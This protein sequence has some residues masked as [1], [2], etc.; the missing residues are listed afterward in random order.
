MR[1]L[2]FFLCLISAFGGCALPNEDLRGISNF[3]PQ[4][5]QLAIQLVREGSDY[6]LK[7]RYFNAEMKFRE[8]DYLF[9]KRKNI[10]VNLVNTLIRTRQF[11]LAKESIDQLSL[12]L[13]N[14]LDVKILFAKYYQ[15]KGDYQSAIKSFKQ[16]LTQARELEVVDY[17]ATIAENLSAIYFLIGEEFLALKYAGHSYHLF[18]NP[19]SKANY[20]RLEVAVGFDHFSEDLKINPNRLNKADQ[21]FL[22]WQLLMTQVANSEQSVKLINQMRLLSGEKAKFSL[23]LQYL[24][25]LNK[26]EWEEDDREAL[27]DKI[28]PALWRTGRLKPDVRLYWPTNLIQE[29]KKTCL[30]FEED[31]IISECVIL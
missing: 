28:L 23:D 27:V 14:D 24:E 5:E 15:A 18:N 11:D 10:E 1:H 17:Q 2:L 13:P 25:I 16:C 9:P 6:F 3:V 29:L 8:A 12:R 26:P 20:A 7:G 30:Q 21:E 19:E 4:D 22:T 31:P